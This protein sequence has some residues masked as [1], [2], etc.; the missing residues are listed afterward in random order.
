M[1]LDRGKL[2]FWGS[3]DSDV[4]V[5]YGRRIRE[6]DRSVS[7]IFWIFGSRIMKGIF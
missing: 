4:G 6:F 3:C 2:Y 5:L 1:E 7:G